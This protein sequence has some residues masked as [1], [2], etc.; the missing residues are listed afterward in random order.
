MRLYKQIIF[1]QWLEKVIPNYTNYAFSSNA[2][3]SI[4]LNQRELL[5]VVKQ[6]NLWIQMNQVG[7]KVYQVSLAEKHTHMHAHTF[8]SI[9]VL[10]LK[11]IYGDVKSFCGIFF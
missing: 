8:R 5:L 11:Y 2:A 6:T 10:Y 7:G 4:Q 3:Y 9:K 1:F